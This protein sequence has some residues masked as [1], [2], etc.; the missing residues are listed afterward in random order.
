MLAAVQ[1]CNPS[2][3]KTLV[4]CYK[5]VINLSKRT[6]PCGSVT[7]LYF[8]FAQAA[9]KDWFLTREGMWR[10]LKCPLGV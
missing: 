3:I 5:E 8:V 1:K 7:F 6:G 9:L 4:N 2:E 10:R